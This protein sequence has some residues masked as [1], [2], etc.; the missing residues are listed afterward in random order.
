MS[1][2]L[3]FYEKGLR[4]RTTKMRLDRLRSSFAVSSESCLSV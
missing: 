4:A 3:F 1:L 2:L